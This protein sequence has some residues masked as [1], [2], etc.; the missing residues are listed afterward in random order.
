MAGRRPTRRTYARTDRVNEVL[1]EII[2]DDMAEVDHDALRVFTVTGIEVTREFEHATVYWTSLD[3]EDPICV[4]EI[5][6]VLEDLRPRLQASIAAQVRLRRT[7]VLR[8]APDPGVL[9]GRRIDS[10]LGEVHDY[11]D[12]TE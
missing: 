7:P 3:V 6:R 12:S 9:D 11:G 8:F 10:L 5:Q 4:A 2:A 1:R